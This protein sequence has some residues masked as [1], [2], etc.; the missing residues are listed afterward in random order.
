MICSFCHD[1]QASSTFSLERKGGQAAP[2]L[3]DG[4]QRLNLPEHFEW[5]T[6][7]GGINSFG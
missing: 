5:N 3:R 1:A 7:Q 2:N 4:I 6:R